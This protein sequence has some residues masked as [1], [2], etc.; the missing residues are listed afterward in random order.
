MYTD[1]KILLLAGL[2]VFMILFLVFSIIF[3]RVKNLEIT[4]SPSGASYSIQG[5]SSGTTPVKLR[6]S[7]GKHIIKITKGS[8]KTINAN[9]NIP[10]WGFQKIHYDLEY[11]GPKKSDTQTSLQERIDTREKYNHDFPFAKYLPFH[12]NNFYMT[13]P[14]NDGTLNIYYSPTNEAQG[15]AEAETWLQQHQVNT[16]NLKINWLPGVE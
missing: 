10:F 12:G 7:P 3:S 5:D 11:N 6:L 16:A 14:S 4:T 2:S 9:I 1:R 15:K 13:P 8:Y